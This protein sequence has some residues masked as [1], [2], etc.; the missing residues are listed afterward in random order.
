M[1]C[2]WF[3]FFLSFLFF[4]SFSLF[5]HFPGPQG[6]YAP[7]ATDKACLVCGPGFATNKKYGSTACADCSPGTMS[8]G[9][10]GNCTIC[11]AG[12]YSGSRSALCIVCD[13]GTYQP[14]SGQASCSACDAGKSTFGYNASAICKDCEAGK[15]STVRAEF[16]QECPAGFS[17]DKAGLSQQ[18]PEE[19]KKGRSEPRNGCGIR[20]FWTSWKGCGD[21]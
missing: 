7:T 19:Q 4:S 10:S 18:V 6:T 3:I 12:R 16:C 1:T 17:A 5:P 15:Y 8:P 14:L 2:K 13:Y 20:Y 21:Y 11:G 9:S